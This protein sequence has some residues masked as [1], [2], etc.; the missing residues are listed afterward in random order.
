MVINLIH[1]MLAIRRNDNTSRLARCFCVVL[2]LLLAMASCH[3]ANRS[4]QAQ[5]VQASP[6]DDTDSEL[7]RTQQLLGVPVKEFPQPQGLSGF[8]DLP[9]TTPVFKFSVTPQPFSG[10]KPRAWYDQR[11]QVQARGPDGT[12]YE[13]YLGHNDPKVIVPGTRPISTTENTRQRY[14]SHYGYGYNPQDIFIGQRQ[15]GRLNVTLFFR[16]AGSH[17]T[18]PHY[19]AIDSKRRAHLA[20]ADVNIFQ[21]NRLDLYWTIGDLV[22]GKWTEAWLMDRRG[23]TSWSHPWMGAWGDKV[24]L[25]WTWCNANNNR[26][27]PGTGIFHTESSNGGFSRKVRIVAGNVRSFDAAIDPQSGRLLIVFSKDIDDANVYVVSRSA[28]G[29]WTQPA[30]LPVQIAQGDNGS[31]VEANGAGAFIIRIGSTDTNQWL[32]NP[33]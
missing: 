13:A 23:F 17:D 12:I 29:S 4:D 25:I 9:T 26:T 5:V 16:D 11:K 30:R 21:D 2:F 31:S 14:G 27:P 19:L 24:Q 6:A 1:L 7:V 15:A 28:D 8:D 22:S 10:A 3:I 33:K 18:A 32:L 20:V